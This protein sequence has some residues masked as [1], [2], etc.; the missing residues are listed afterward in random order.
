MP[1][2]SI[3]LTRIR[4]IRFAVPSL[5]TDARDR[6]RSVRRLPSVASFGPTVGAY[7]PARRGLV[8]AA[9]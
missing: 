9:S 8:E 7:Q 5:R 1:V 2:P 6:A 4:T 3:S